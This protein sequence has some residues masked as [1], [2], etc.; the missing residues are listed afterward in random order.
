MYRYSYLGPKEIARKSKSL[1]P[2]KRISCS[3]DICSWIEENNQELNGS[4][5]IT[6]TFIIS[7]ESYLLIADRRSEHI[8]CAGG[9]PVLSACEMTLEVRGNEVELIEATNQSTGYCP[10]PD[11]WNAVEE[12]LHEIGVKH[13][14]TFTKAY[15]FRRCPKCK[16]LNIIKDD[17]YYCPV[18]NTELPKQ[19]NM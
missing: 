1:K 11:S 17:F 18:C 9:R 19:W 4:G 10:K 7:E 15:E 2:G 16:M 6:V 12:A 5:A 13:P 14:F 8:A 3:D